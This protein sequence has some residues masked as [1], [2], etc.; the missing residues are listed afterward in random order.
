VRRERLACNDVGRGFEIEAQLDRIQAQPV[1]NSH[2]FHA[3]PR[4]IRLFRSLPP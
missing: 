1:G 3:M 4:I 2:R